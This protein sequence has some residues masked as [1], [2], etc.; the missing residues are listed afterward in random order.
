MGLEDV[1]PDDG[2]DEKPGI[3]WQN[4]HLHNEEICPHCEEDQTEK[5]RYYYR[6][7]NTECPVTTYIPNLRDRISDLL[8]K[9]L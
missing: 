6:C 1:L 3:K 4:E 5:V 2:D 8:E 7:H 9:G